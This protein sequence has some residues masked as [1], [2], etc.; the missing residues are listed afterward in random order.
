MPAPVTVSIAPPIVAWS[1]INDYDGSSNLIYF[2][3]ALSRQPNAVT[4]T[5]ATISKAASGVVTFVA[6]GLQ[7]DQSVTI[8]GGTGD[9]AGVNGAQKITKIDADTFSIPI[10]TSGYAGTF[11][12]TVT[13]TAAQTNALC[14]SI[15][16]NYYD[17]SNR[18]TRS[19]WANGVTTALYA[20][21]SRTTYPYL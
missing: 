2:G 3:Y 6:H 14:W 11:A 8:A 1:S 12:G 20:W 13:T 10:N 5:G 17:G 18:L 16:K 21:D 19:A 7:S 4:L 15:Q 9:W